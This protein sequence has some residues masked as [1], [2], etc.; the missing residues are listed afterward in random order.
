MDI[1]EIC[2]ENVP[3]A[4]E[5]IRVGL[6]EFGFNEAGIYPLIQLKGVGTWN[7]EK[8]DCLTVRISIAG[9]NEFD[10]T[11]RVF[12]LANYLKRHFNQEA[13]LVT[14]VKAVGI[15]LV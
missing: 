9:G 12:N 1:Y 8:E 13:V 11:T 6:H 5:R 7:L 10:N 2:T 15:T 14:H 4:I 3:G